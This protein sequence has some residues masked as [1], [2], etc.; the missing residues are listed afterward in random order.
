MFPIEIAGKVSLSLSLEDHSAPIKP[1]DFAS[2]S[3]KSNPE[4]SLSHRKSLTS[5]AEN[6]KA[7]NSKKSFRSQKSEPKK[8]PLIMIFVL[9]IFGYFA[10]SQILKTQLNEDNKNLESNTTNAEST[11][12]QSKLNF[13]EINLKSYRQNNQCSE[14]GDLCS[15]LGVDNDQG[16]LHKTNKEL[17]IFVNLSKKSI[18]NPHKSFEE[19]DEM[20]KSEIILS[21][22]GSL[23]KLMLKV[24]ELKLSKLIIVGYG[25]IDSNIFLKMA[26]DVDFNSLL[27]LPGNL[28]LF[29]SD[30]YF[31]GITRGYRNNIVPHQTIYE[32]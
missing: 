31:G 6:T 2:S 1:M 27:K 12:N 22:I 20:K 24:M 18:Q 32:L 13:N 23:R 28:N 26:I 11:K 25:E 8:S 17:F 7:V 15:F 19:L 5:K 10:Y 14:M 16:S 4:K 3:L 29:F 21:E 30:L 9:A